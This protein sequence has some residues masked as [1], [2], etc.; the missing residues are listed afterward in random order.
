M[1]AAASLIVLS[2]NLDASQVV[3][4][5]YDSNGNV[6]GSTSTI[7]GHPV[8][9]STATGFATVTFDTVA[10]TITTDLSWDGLSGNADRMHLHD[11][12]P[13]I[14]RLEPP[15]DRFFHEVIRPAYFDGA[16]FFDSSVIG[17]TVLC[18]GVERPGVD[19]VPTNDTCAPQTGELFDV[20]SLTAAYFAPNSPSPERVTGFPDFAAL[21]SAATADG[22]F[23]DIHTEL[24]PGGEIRGQLLYTSTV[25]E[26]ATLGLLGLGLFALV[27]A[28]RVPRRQG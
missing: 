5:V 13:G 11:A 23:L 16:N 17:G 3:A 18:G 7:D 24:Y 19:W 12:P 8:S 2:G 27:R 4:P 22:M 25:P 26:P 28:R 6:V 10:L 20:L 1:P 14:S 9:T 15:N 21:V